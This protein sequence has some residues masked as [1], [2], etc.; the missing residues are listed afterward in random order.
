MSFK[1]FAKKCIK[2]SYFNGLYEKGYFNKRIIKLR[3]KNW[4]FQRIFRVNSDIPWAV[5]FTSKVT[6]PKNIKFGK[7]VWENFLVSGNCYI[8]GGNGISIGDNTMWGPGVGIISANHDPNNMRKWK[9]EKPINMGKNCWIGMNSIILPG[10]T[11]GDNVIVGAGSIVT[12]SFK[13]NVV[14][15]GNPAKIIKEL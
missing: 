13:K 8:Q 7:G 9:K 5:N 12:K 3:I 1:E 6:N 10:I 11:L 4:V 15:G 14:I 2:K